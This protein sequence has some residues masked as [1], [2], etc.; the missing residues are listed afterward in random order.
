MENS[1][2][3]NH[4]L[5]AAC[6]SCLNGSDCDSK[7]LGNCTYICRLGTVTDDEFM[8]HI[9][10]TVCYYENKDI[11]DKIKDDIEK[12]YLNSEKDSAELK[13]LRD[14]LSN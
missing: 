13:R 12:K 3:V 5:D 10:D 14:I 8:G 11:K 7:Q 6:Q 2:D 4:Y 9:N 1:K